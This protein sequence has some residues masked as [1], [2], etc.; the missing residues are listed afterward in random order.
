MKYIK[1][2]RDKTPIKQSGWEEAF[3]KYVP[4]LNDIPCVKSGSTSME[5]ARSG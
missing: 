4:A 2:D 5:D 3:N 1:V